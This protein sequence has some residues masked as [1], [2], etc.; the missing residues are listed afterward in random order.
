MKE[1][2]GRGELRC[3]FCSK[4]TTEVELII[5]GP[6]VYICDECVELSMDIIVEARGGVGIIFRRKALDDLS[7]GALITMAGGAPDRELV[8]D[9]RMGLLLDAYVS[10]AT[11]AASL[12]GEGCTER[13]KKEVVDAEREVGKLKQRLSVAEQLKKLMDGEGEGDEAEADQADS[14]ESEG[15]DHDDHDCDD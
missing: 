1:A 5:E 10:L 2:A 3:S 4:H 7:A 14:D 9:H 6:S 13:L 8:A 12:G 11:I 15:G